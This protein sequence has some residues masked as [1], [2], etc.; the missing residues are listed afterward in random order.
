MALVTGAS[1]GSTVTAIALRLAAEGARLAITA[2]ITRG[3]NRL[4][5]AE[6]GLRTC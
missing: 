4:G 5:S 6:R 1:K 3:A 2:S